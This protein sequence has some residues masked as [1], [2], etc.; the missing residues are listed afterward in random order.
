MSAE[1]REDMKKGWSG[2]GGGGSGGVLQGR[3]PG[4]QQV[5]PLVFCHSNFP[6][7]TLFPLVVLE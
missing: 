3:F 1:E 5:K 6:Y 4:K 7:V 2:T